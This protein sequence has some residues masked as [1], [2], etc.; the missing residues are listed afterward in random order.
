M[1]GLVIAWAATAIVLAFL[2]LGRRRGAAQAL[3]VSAALSAV[4]CV[5]GTFASLLLALPAFASII[6]VAVLRRP[7]VRAWL[8]GAKR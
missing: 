8:A 5:V 7:D 2:T 4:L 6:T 3:M 1:G